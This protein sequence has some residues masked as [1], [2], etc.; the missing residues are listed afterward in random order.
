MN[1]HR[2]HMGNHR[3]DRSTPGTELRRRR[4]AVEAVMG[5][6]IVVLIVQMW[7]LTATLES[8]LAGHAEPA[9]PAFLVSIVLTAACG[10]LYLMVLRLDR[11][12]APEELPPSSS[13]P[14]E[15]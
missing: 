8:Y 7:L 1:T 12:K 13:S 14:W 9:G 11:S 6:V 15:I 10:G 5:C 2:S 3:S 4:V